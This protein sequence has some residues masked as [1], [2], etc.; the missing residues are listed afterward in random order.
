MNNMEKQRILVPRGTLCMEEME[1]IAAY[2]FR[3]GYTVR[4]R[5]I[6]S[7]SNKGS[8]YIEYWIE[9]EEGNV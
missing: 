8:K 5:S 1:R 2:L 9:G 6:Q 4:K 3:I 7:G